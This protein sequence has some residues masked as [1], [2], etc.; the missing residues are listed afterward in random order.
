[1]EQLP[2][3]L[4]DNIA[5]QIDNED[6]KALHQVSRALN[7][8][9]HEAFTKRFFVT[10]K[11]D[12]SLDCMNQLINLMRFSPFAS[13]V[14]NLVFDTIRQPDDS[15]LSVKIAE[16]MRRFAGRELNSIT[17]INSASASL[18]DAAMPHNVK[19]C[20]DVA[21]FR[22]RTRDTNSVTRQILIPMQLHGIRTCKFFVPG[23]W[24]TYAI[25][26][27]GL[28]FFSNFFSSL[29]HLDLFIYPENIHKSEDQDALVRREASYLA[30]FIN[31]CPQ[32]SNL[33]LGTT[34]DIFV[35][36]PTSSFTNTLFS[37]LVNLD[38]LKTVSL[39][40][41]QDITYTTFLSFLTTSPNIS[42]LELVRMS[43]HAEELQKHMGWV[44]V[45][46]HLLEYKSI[47]HFSW[48][49]LW[50]ATTLENYDQSADNSLVEP[51]SG[52]S[53]THVVA[54]DREGC[55]EKVHCRNDG[56]YPRATVK[57]RV[58]VEKTLSCML[59]NFERME[60]FH[61]AEERGWNGDGNGGI[62]IVY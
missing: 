27:S 24:R 20:N 7:R 3:E 54:C 34:N 1:M 37:N 31:K 26:C 2:T 59:A 44:I 22:N 15:H 36:F 41:W 25:S 14:Q 23:A 8:H 45:L 29:R 55:V 4:I 49:R 16:I 62:E 13:L 28:I 47:T 51:P 11:L 12:T 50:C 30:S 58:A 5:D 61:L 38:L 35:W 56:V 18:M 40:G 21:R 17:F 39:T 19:Y 6:L 10:R 9:T 33:R 32:L 48:Q 60:R 43:I 42:R 53:S 52:M 46:R 57:G